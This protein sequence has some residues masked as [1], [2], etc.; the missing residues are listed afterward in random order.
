MPKRA[1]VAG[2]GGV[3]ISGSVSLAGDIVGRDKIVHGLTTEELVDELEARGIVAAAETAGLQRR[4]ITVNLAAR[5]RSSGEQ[6]DFEQAVTELE[7]A[8][9][10]A[11]DVVGEVNATATKTTSSMLSWRRS[12]TEP[13]AVI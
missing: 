9:E 1:E 4:V 8:V 13:K 2:N 3:A 12:P 6:L 5:L 11:L 10:I 7:R